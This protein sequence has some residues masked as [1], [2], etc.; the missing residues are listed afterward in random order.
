MSLGAG[1]TGSARLRSRESS[2]RS[3]NPA[4]SRRI[5]ICRGI[6][7]RFAAEPGIPGV[8]AI[9]QP[10]GRQDG[11]ALDTSAR[12]ARRANR[13]TRM[14]PNSPKNLRAQAPSRRVAILV[15]A[16]LLLA[17]GPG[18]M[19]QEAGDSAPEKTPLG[20]PLAP[21]WKRDTSPLALATWR[22]PLRADLVIL[23]SDAGVEALDPQSGVTRWHAELPF[24]PRSAAFHGDLVLVGGVARTTGGC[25][26]IALA[27]SDGRER[28]RLAAGGVFVAPIGI[29]TAAAARFVVASTHR[30]LAFDAASG[31]VLWQVDFPRLANGLPGG[32]GLSRPAWIGDLIVAGAGDGRLH[33]V[34]AS[35]GTRRWSIP[36]PRT[37]Q[38]GVAA[39]ENRIVVTSGSYV[40]GF[41]TLGNER[42]RYAI[43]GDADFATPVIDGG[44]VYSGTGT[45]GAVVALSADSG[46]L[47]WRMPLG[48]SVWTQPA[49]ARDHLV[50]GDLANQL[51][52]LR[53][54]DGQEAGRWSMGPT[55]GIY[56]AD[57]AFAG[58]VVGV[59]TTAGSY[60]LFAAAS[61]SADDIAMPA[62]PATQPL[63]LAAPN[64]FRST[65]RIH[66]AAEAMPAHAGSGSAQFVRIADVQGRTV[67]VLRAEPG[68]SVTW[69]GRN[70]VGQRV[71][72]RTYFL[73]MEG[74]APAARAKV[75]LLPD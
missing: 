41:D 22:A 60:H 53:R 46:R 35:D 6:R 55:G 58:E 23:P 2:R 7:A 57:P 65:T 74:A 64:P 37:L 16:G 67:R 73:M 24:S 9:L 36:V 70:E 10:H 43:S 62:P 63:L 54:V 69:D 30:L 11:A 28:Y 51:T 14:R 52:V 32:P 13:P 21:L 44:I 39:T 34:S 49:L 68:S 40:M 45:N 48:A 50:V 75:E 12:A 1:A 15:L 72:A 71:A 3:A 25:D 31:T 20:L 56:L 5:R 59:G 33:A 66:I 47:Q 26:L 29:G 18:A 17:S 38:S 8:E 4:S 61:T 19:A 42:W 27:V